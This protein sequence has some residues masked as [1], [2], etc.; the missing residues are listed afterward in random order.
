M[1]FMCI[2]IAMTIL[3]VAWEGISQ[4]GPVKGE[5]TAGTKTY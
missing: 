1:R 3:V 2:R 4:D 5:K